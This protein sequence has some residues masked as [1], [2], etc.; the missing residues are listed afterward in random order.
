[1]DR[2]TYLLTTAFLLGA[3]GAAWPQDKGPAPP[4]VPNGIYAVRR[5][6]LEEKEV[7]PIKDGEVLLVNRHRYQK[8]D[9]KEPPRYLVVR[10]SPEVPLDLAGEPMAD[11]DGEEVVRIRLKLRPQAAVA[12]ERLTRAQQAKQIAIVLNGEVVT[13][14][15][16]RSVIRNGDAQITSC[17]PGAAGYLFRQ[18]QA[19]AQGK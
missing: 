9:D 19:V 17:A 10:A 16:V 4:K 18:L 12:L 7:L 8:N 2:R 3:P 5:D 11:R 14:H 15:K 1:M 6:S 13:M